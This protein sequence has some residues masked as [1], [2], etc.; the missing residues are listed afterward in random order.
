M[1]L[2]AGRLDDRFAVAFG[3]ARL[4]ARAGR[5]CG[6]RRN[7]YDGAGAAS[8]TAESSIHS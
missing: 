7:G 3:Q 5:D 2:P 8:L 6:R 4:S 1:T